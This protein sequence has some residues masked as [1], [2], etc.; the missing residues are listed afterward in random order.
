MPNKEDIAAMLGWW[1]Y[2]DDKYASDGPHLIAVGAYPN[3]EAAQKAGDNAGLIDGILQEGG[4]DCFWDEK[5]PEVMKAEDY[6]TGYTM[7]V[8]LVDLTDPDHTGEYGEEDE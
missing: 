5:P 1:V 8:I 2:I 7:E 6:F 4:S 3:E